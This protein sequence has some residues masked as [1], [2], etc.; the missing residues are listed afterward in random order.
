MYLKYHLTLLTIKRDGYELTIKQTVVG[1]IINSNC[2]VW[3]PSF[4]IMQKNAM[5]I[6]FDTTPKE[7]KTIASVNIIQLQI[8]SKYVY[9]LKI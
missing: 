3:S 9:I 1:V 5:Y 4:L 2:S 7:I 6:V 8:H